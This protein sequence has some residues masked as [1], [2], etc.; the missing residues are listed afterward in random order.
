MLALSIPADTTPESLIRD[1]LPREHKA[2]VPAGTRGKSK[3]GV[4][5]DR[6][7]WALS[8]DGLSATAT[9]DRDLEG[10]DFRLHTTRAA[11][12]A[13]IADWLG[14]KTLLPT[15]LPA[16]DLPRV[17]TDPRILA[18]VTAVTGSLELALR[19]L[20]IGGKKTRVSIVIVAGS[21]TK[22]KYFYEEPD[23]I[24]ETSVATYKR[25]LAGKL[26]PDAALADGDVTVSGKKLV[27]MQY[28]FAVAP[29]Q[30]KA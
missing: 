4:T 26:T 15:A 16:G 1:V 29:F 8:V 10:C 14:P 12:L 18:R 23:A 7:S 3:I 11:A 24:V 9:E 6:A 2:H 20:E 19:D 28:A 25:I 21:A 27:A 30:P 17:P 22:K 13:F 5:I